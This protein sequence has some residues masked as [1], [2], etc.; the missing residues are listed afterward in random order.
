[1]PS[2]LPTKTV[3]PL[4][5]GAVTSVPSP[6]VQM[7]GLPDGLTATR[8]APYKVNV[9]LSPNAGAVLEAKL[10]TDEPLV[11]DSAMGVSRPN[12]SNASWTERGIVFE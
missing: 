9:S 11:F 12:T 4:T 2:L 8:L 5:T 10:A 6:K 7:S 1:M 3:L